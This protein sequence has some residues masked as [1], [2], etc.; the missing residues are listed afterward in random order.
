MFSSIP[1]VLVVDDDASVIDLLT[2]YLEEKNFIVVSTNFDEAEKVFSANP[3]IIDSVVINGDPRKYDKILLLNEK[4]L[5]TKPETPRAVLSNSL[6]DDV[7]QES[8]KKWMCET[9]C[10]STRNY[11]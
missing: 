2:G 1:T 10:C 5:E 7:P 11:K 9:M 4:I 6:E 8:K 3:D